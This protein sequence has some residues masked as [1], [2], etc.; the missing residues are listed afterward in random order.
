MNK[1]IAIFTDVHGNSPALR[2]VLEEIDKNQEVE[3]I[4]CLGDMIA[5]GPDTNEVLNILFSRNDLS[6]ITGNHDEAV[7]SLLK[8]EEYPKSLA[9]ARNHHEWIAKRLDKSFIPKLDLLP[10][11]IRRDELSFS[12]LFI[13]YHIV[14]DKL[15][16][17]ISKDPFSSIVEPNLKNLEE[18]FHDYKDNMVCFGH[19]HPVHF[20]H[21]N[22]QIFL[23]P[24]SLGCNDKP[25]A[26]FAVVTIHSN[27]IQVE[28]KEVVYDNSDF[29][30]SYNK[31][32][33]PDREFILKIFYGNQAY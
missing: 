12:L 22:R 7:L 15:N 5:I 19:H 27:G 20:F 1:K 31:L 32:E 10:R 25:I 30:A 11:F 2:A 9:L 26:R 33:V 3:H 16:H 24:G 29:L 13:H 4:Y 21:N 14:R 23:N 17:H 18:L 28:L 6:M 8:G